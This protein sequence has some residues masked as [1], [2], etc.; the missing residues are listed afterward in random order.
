V[1]VSRDPSYKVKTKEGT[2]GRKRKGEF[3]RVESR[4]EVIDK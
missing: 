3:E 2:E 4:K 1:E